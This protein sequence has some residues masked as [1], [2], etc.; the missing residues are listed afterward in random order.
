MN[1]FEAPNSIIMEK[2]KTNFGIIEKITDHFIVFSYNSNIEIGEFEIKEVL[3]LLK[4]YV[5]E[6]GKIKLIIEIPQTTIMTLEAMTYLQVNKY[7][8]ENT[9]ALGLVMKSIAQRVGSKFYHTKVEVGVPT[10]FFK[11]KE[12][13]IEWIGKI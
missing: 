12:E 9:I 1:T 4:D 11:T 3:S 5:A 10:K 2:K 13:A 8:N 6:Y 7:K